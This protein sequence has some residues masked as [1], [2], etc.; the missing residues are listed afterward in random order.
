LGTDVLDIITNPFYAF[1][2]VLAFNGFRLGLSSTSSVPSSSSAFSGSSAPS[3][4]IGKNLMVADI[5][6]FYDLTVS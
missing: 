4:N 1:L 3:S 2:L 6:D 5:G